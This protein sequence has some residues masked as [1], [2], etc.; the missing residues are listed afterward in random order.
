MAKAKWDPNRTKFSYCQ[1]RAEKALKSLGLDLK[2]RRVITSRDKEAAKLKKTLRTTNVPSGFT[3]WQLPFIF[4]KATT[5]MVI[6][7]PGAKAKTHAHKHGNALRYIVSGSI[8]YKR[9]DLTAG[10]W[11]FVPQGARYSFT[12]GDY[13]YV[14]SYLYEC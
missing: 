12:V 5:F 11:M 9:Q 1:R 8:K 3:K 2:K 6:G 4:E 13:G 10:D 7:E 14:G